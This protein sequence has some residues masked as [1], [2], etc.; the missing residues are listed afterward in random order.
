[1]TNIRKHA[2]ASEVTIELVKEAGFVILSVQ[3]NG[4]GIENPEAGSENVVLAGG[5]QIPAGHFG[6]IGI[7]E[8]VKSLGGNFQ[9]TSAPNQG[10]T[11]RVELP[12]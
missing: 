5:W 2:Q 8:R 1:L 9:L 12:L 4:V 11:I 7:Q 10:T 6:L 3:D